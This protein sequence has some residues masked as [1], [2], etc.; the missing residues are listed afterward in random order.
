[1]DI[2]KRQKLAKY[3]IIRLGIQ[4][5]ND[6]G[7]NKLSKIADENTDHSVTEENGSY[8]SRRIIEGKARWIIVDKNGKIID[9]NPNKECIKLAKSFKYNPTD[10][11]DNCGVNIDVWPRP[12]REYKKGKRT[13][14]WLCW[15]CYDVSKFDTILHGKKEDLYKSY[16]I[17]DGKTK[18]V[19]V[20]NNGNIIDKNPKKEQIEVA[21]NFKY[22][23]TDTC[24]ICG[25]S[26]YLANHHRESD[27]EGKMTGRWLC[28]KCCGRYDPNSSGNIRKSLRG[29]RTGNL[30]P[31]CKHAIGDKYQRLTCEW[32]GI[33]DLNI[34]NDNYEVPIDHSRHPFYGIVQT[35]GRAYDPINGFWNYKWERE[36]K[37][38]F[39]NIIVYCT[40]KDGKTIER[41]YI[42]PKEE[43]I[44]S[45]TVS[46]V[47]NPT[48]GIQWYEKYRLE[49]DI[50]IHVN[51]IFKNLK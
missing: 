50:V 10:T 41:I 32:L 49:E 31:Y 36:H 23:P 47:K 26:L 38:D 8:K 40:D 15:E 12:R 4:M 29:R 19:I 5:N 51:D 2:H 1:M 11:C 44:K 28:D 17:I 37:K 24:D 3:E 30:D 18:W 6:I 39:N 16:R 48:K 22:N 7:Q 34:E 9:K 35:T 33:K 14:R 43:V 27:K 45:K 13:G 21:K 42:F 20:D 25:I 46:I